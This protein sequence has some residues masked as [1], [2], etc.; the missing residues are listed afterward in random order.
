MITMAAKIKMPL[1]KKSF[2]KSL[3]V[4]TCSSAVW[5]YAAA[6]LDD[7]ATVAAPDTAAELTGA[8]MPAG[9]EPCSSAAGS[10]SCPSA[11]GAS[12]RSDT[13]S[14]PSAAAAASC[15][16]TATSGCS[17]SLCRFVP[18]IY[19]NRPVARAPSPSRGSGRS[20]RQHGEEFRHNTSPYRRYKNT[21]HLRESRN[22]GPACT[23]A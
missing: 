10:A 2:Q 4:L 15:P 23:A 5:R 6:A 18:L 19:A 16:L 13:A 7:A 21:I 17:A 9:A 1:T 3:R 22:I 12:T 14:E 11:A 20:S 8:V